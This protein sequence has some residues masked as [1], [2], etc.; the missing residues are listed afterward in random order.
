[1]PAG[2][3]IRV[4]VLLLA[5][6]LAPLF[7]ARPAAAQSRLRRQR[8]VVLQQQKRPSAGS[9]TRCRRRCSKRPSC[10]NP[11]PSRSGIARPSATANLMALQQQSALQNALQQTNALLQATYNRGSSLAEFALRQQNT[12]QVA[13][14]QTTTLQGALLAQNGQLP[15]HQ[16]QLLS[17]EQTS[18]TGLPNV[19]VSFRADK[20]DPQIIPSNR[21]QKGK[22]EYENMNL[23]GRIRSARAGQRHRRQNSCRDLRTKGRTRDCGRAQICGRFVP[24]HRVPAQQEHHPQRQGCLVLFSQQR[25]RHQ[26]RECSHQTS[27]QPCRWRCLAECRTPRYATRS[28]LIP[29]CRK[30]LSSSLVTSLPSPAHAAK[31]AR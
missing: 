7:A 24:E 16:L 11:L 28:S 15:P 30:G 14:Q 27:W 12:L 31:R 5:A 26:Q 4:V 1:M 17:Q 29:P 3:R 2:S 18:L 10:S 19:P 9:R 25:I 23:N 22:T 20:A 21:W 6:A 13:L 8:L